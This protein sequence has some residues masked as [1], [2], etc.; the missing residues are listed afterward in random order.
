MFYVLCY[1]IIFF[2]KGKLTD[3]CVIKICVLRINHMCYIRRIKIDS[4]SEKPNIFI[5]IKFFNI[6][7]LLFYH[8]FS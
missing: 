6:L 8:N 4:K 2:E 1:E 3:F 5:R 7:C